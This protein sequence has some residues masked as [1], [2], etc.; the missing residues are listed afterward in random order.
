MADASFPRG[1][2]E[3]PPPPTEKELKKAQLDSKRKK[4]TVASDFLFGTNA[5]DDK[6]KKRKTSSTGGAS[7]SKHSLLPLGGGGVVMHTQGKK[8]EPLIEALSF[9]KLAKGTK[10]LGFV[11]EVHDEFAVLSLPNLLTG[12][13]LQDGLPLTKCVQIGQCLS[14]SI[15]KI[16]SEHVSGGQQ[17]RRIQVSAK[18]A[19]MNSQDVPSKKLPTRGQVLSVEDHGCLVDLGFGRKGF[20]PFEE[21]QGDHAVLDEDE[22]AEE[23]TKGRILQKG[24]F[25]DFFVTNS[26][27]AVFKLSLPSVAKMAK[28]VLVP[29]SQTP[30][31]ASISPGWLVQAKMESLAKNGLCVTFFGNVFRGAVELGHLGGLFESET[32]DGSTAWRDVFNHQQ[33]FAARILAVDPV[34]KLIRL[35]I[36]PHLLQMRLPD[37]LPD[38]GTLIEE[39]K[40][41]RLD[42]GIGALLALPEEYNREDDD[43]KPWGLFEEESFREAA[44]VKGV[45]VHIS[46]AIDEKDSSVFAKQ[47]APSTAHKVRI[48]SSMNWIEG[49]A[50]GACAPSIIEAHVLTH[51]DLKPGELYR[52]VPVCAHLNGGSILVDLGSGIRGLVPPLHLFETSASSA[53]RQKLLKAKFAIDAKVDVRV[54]WVDTKRKKCLLTAK[55]GIIKQSE[56]ITSYE[57]IKIGQKATG[58]I[59]KIDDRSL[60]VTFCNRVYGK[61]TARSLAAEL[62]IEDHRE[63]YQVG[64]VVTS[65]IVNL[66]K[67]ARGNYAEDFQDDDD[68]EEDDDE[69]VGRAYYEVTL[70][71]KGHGEDADDDDDMEDAE[72]AAAQAP[73][74]IHVKAGAVLAL[75]SMMIV[76]LVKGKQK[77]KGGFVPGY[78]I[79][80]VKSKYLLDE[81]ECTTMLPYME[82]KL[83]YDQLADDYMPSDIESAEAMDALAEKILTVGQKLNQRGI[84]LTD[85]HKSNVDFS[86]GIG[87]LTTL[88]LRKKLIEAV[89][90]QGTKPED[91][92]MP[93]PESHMFVGALITGYVAQ[94]DSRHGAFIRFLDGMTGLIPKRKGGLDLPLYGTVVTRVEV[95]DDTKSPPKILLKAISFSKRKADAVAHTVSLKPGDKIAEAKIVKLDFH[96]AT[97]RVLDQEVGTHINV[98][99]HCTMTDSAV[100]KI[101]EKKKKK[102]KSGGKGD[103]KLP[104][105]ECHPFSNW[106]TGQTLK[107]LTVVSVEKSNKTSYVQVTDH[108]SG[109]GNA[110]GPTFLKN[111]SQV[112]TGMMV[113]GIVT[114]VAPQNKG[115][116]IQLSPSVGGFIPALELSTSINL[117]NN[118]KSNFDVGARLRCRVMD[119]KH[120]REIRSKCPVLRQHGGKERKESGGAVFLSLL[121][122]DEESTGAKQPKPSRGDMVIGRINLK[123]PNALA[124][125]LMMDLRGGFVGRCCI[126]ELEEVDEWENMPLGRPIVSSG[127]SPKKSEKH[128]TKSSGKDDGK[129]EVEEPKDDTETGDE[130]YVFSLRFKAMHKRNGRSHILP[131]VKFRSLSEECAYINLGGWCGEATQIQQLVSMNYHLHFV[132]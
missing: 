69:Q 54:L 73:T 91:I 122:A 68:F 70:S 42:P 87:R 10:L 119:E 99:I 95:I 60:F 21:V 64:D 35:S 14:V 86:S 100:S 41:V 112:S 110:D 17:R 57:D 44:K 115:I 104:I 25:Y 58:Y 45:Y 98:S 1:G 107:N 8:I 90:K 77:E 43:S 33:S 2:R 59:S 38:V 7:T 108:K 19:V 80:S 124:P 103:E 37:S 93:S 16:V 128:S 4:P 97:L 96:R 6:S 72:D 94:V 109:E 101:D 3:R 13:M 106:K 50:S 18:P 111:E 83:P 79:V 66:K 28:N 15:V 75:K 81:S 118:L 67:R 9:G 34:T 85:P 52:Q 53:Y 123:L 48:L 51:S 88:S 92:T 127:K 71:L 102:R 49:V 132:F 125:S 61:V 36:Q 39:C 74:E 117:M 30:T 31:L 116:Y 20:L 65:R 47:F 5:T 56:A 55:K 131:T 120:W 46:K 114:G 27:D 26:K 105:T 29:S 78:A 82:C 24:R 121:L 129:M 84:I 89:E 22:D 32:R 62:G 76:E 12:Y 40:V 130:R 63:N 23:D 11:R 113:T 126:T